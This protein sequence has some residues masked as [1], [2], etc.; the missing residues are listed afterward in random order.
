MPHLGEQCPNCKQGILDDESRQH[1]PKALGCPNC[2]QAFQD[3]SD[4]E[5]R[6]MIVYRVADE[7]KKDKRFR[8]VTIDGDHNSAEVIFTAP[9]GKQYVLSTSDI[10]EYKET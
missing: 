8:N 4:T 5:A 2:G 3:M 9:N 7:M 1:G 6:K 10:R